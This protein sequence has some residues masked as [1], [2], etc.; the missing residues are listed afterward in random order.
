MEMVPHRLPS[1]P[2]LQMGLAKS[3]DYYKGINL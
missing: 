3:W 2:S 1:H